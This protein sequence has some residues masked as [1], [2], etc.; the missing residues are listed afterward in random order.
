[1]NK[2]KSEK[3]KASDDKKDASTEET[4]EKT[5]DS[6]AEKPPLKSQSRAKKSKA[7]PK[8]SAADKKTTGETPKKS[9]PTTKKR[10]DNKKGEKDKSKKPVYKLLINTVE[11]EECRI[12]LLEDGRIESFHVQTVSREQSK[13]NIYKGKIAAVEPSLQA[14][15][16]EI[17][18][19]KNGFLPFSDIHPEYYYSDVA[20]DTHW[21][22]LKIQ[23]VIRKGQEVLI[24]VVKESVGNKGPN[25][26]T[27]L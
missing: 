9:S 15:F 25:M 8:K 13:G 11:P 14:A 5:A 10:T 2:D 12:A 24:E 22:K 18:T 20:P 26:T 19:E 7:K 21:K 27:Y 4:A 17:G 3:N 16:V 6:K 23:D 1:M